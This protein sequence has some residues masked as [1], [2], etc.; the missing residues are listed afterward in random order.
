MK[1]DQLFKHFESSRGNEKDVSFDLPVEKP[2]TYNPVVVKTVD[3]IRFV[4]NRGFFQPFLRT[5]RFLGRH[6]NLT[7][8][9]VFG[10]VLGIIIGNFAPE[11]GKAVKPLADAFINM[12]KI[13][14]VPLIFSTLV[15]GIAGHGD[16]VSK[17]GKLAVKT[18]IVSFFSLVTF[19][20]SPYSPFFVSSTL[21]W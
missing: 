10:M 1:K 2:A 16:D 15:V 11:A 14:E 5:W 21:K 17:V 4:V 8:W 3:G 9:I 18:I 12:I 7:F 6:T 20:L 19:S 13:I